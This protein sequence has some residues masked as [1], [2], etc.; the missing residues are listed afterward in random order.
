MTPGELIGD[1]EHAVT[2]VDLSS[3]WAELNVYQKDLNTI[4]VGQ[5]V[6]VSYDDDNLFPGEIFYLSPIVDDH[7]RT[8]A[9]RVRL[10]NTSGIWKQVA[11]KE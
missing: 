7:T 5:G 2:I 8:T 3:V 4:K 11:R 9:A 6:Q 10:S 1:D